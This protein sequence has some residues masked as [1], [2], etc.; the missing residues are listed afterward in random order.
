M[1]KLSRYFFIGVFFPLIV[2]YVFYYQFTTNYTKDAFSEQGFKNIYDAKVYKSRQLG[3]RLHLWIYS[4]LSSID[5]MKQLRADA[6]NEKNPFNSKRLSN[7]DVAADPVFYFTYFLMAVF[8]TVLTALLLLY[9]FDDKDLFTLSNSQKELLVLFFV[10]II[11]FTQF[12]IT[13]YDT[14]GYFFEAAGIFFFLKYFKKKNIGYYLGLLLTIIVATINRET[15]LLIISFMAAVYFYLYS[16]K[17]K[18]I[19]ELIVPALC[20]IIPYLVLKL[21]QTGDADFTDESKLAVNLDIRNSY[22]IRGLAFT[23]FVLYFILVTLNKNKTPLVKY[24]LFFALPY[25]IIIHAVGVM[26]EYRLWMPVIEGAIVLSYLDLHFLKQR[27][28]SWNK[29][30][31]EANS[32]HLQP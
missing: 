20:F 6:A 18:W 28:L 23:A 2:Q 16:F 12:V 11:G 10:L 31:D 30:A 14:I 21:A 9:I 22:A 24:F 8:F 5:K 17:L 19:R 7:M 1:Q 29:K 15:S 4:K 25:I 13:P 26:I 32:F 3:K 27:K